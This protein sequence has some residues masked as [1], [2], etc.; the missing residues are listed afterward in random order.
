MRSSQA[1][2][3]LGTSILETFGSGLWHSGMPAKRS[4]AF[5]SRASYLIHHS[6]CWGLGLVILG[7]MP[8]AGLEMGG[9][10]GTQ[11]WGLPMGVLATCFPEGNTYLGMAAAIR[12]SFWYQH[13][14]LFTT[15]LTKPPR[16]ASNVVAWT[17]DYMP[18]AGG[19]LCIGSHVD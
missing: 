15:Q 2:S 11:G 6:L 12:T 10:R 1:T 13:I 4:A 18:S 8:K 7:Q 19:R 3:A 17:V 14:P 5:I 9:I 16:S